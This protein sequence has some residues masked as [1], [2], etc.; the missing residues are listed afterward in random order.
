VRNTR[1]GSEV[2]VDEA[3]G[4]D[5]VGGY[6]SHV[7]YDLPR[8]GLINTD[9][10]ELLSEPLCDEA[11]S[12]IVRLEVRL[13]CIDVIEVESMGAGEVLLMGHT[14]AGVISG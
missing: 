11:F 9:T 8:L 4:L 13:D 3:G 2:G 6:S 12:P 7:K 5:D 14:D 1:S 10:N